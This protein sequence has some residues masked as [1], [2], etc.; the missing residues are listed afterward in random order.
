MSRAEVLQLVAA[1]L[2]AFATLVSAAEQRLVKRLRGAGADD[3]ERAIQLA[4]LS[5]LPRWRLSRLLG[6]GAVGRIEPG[7]YYLDEQAYGGYRRT[8]RVR[9]LTAVAI[10]LVVA[11]VLYLTR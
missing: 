11:G 2:G 3:P 5:P 8:R 1:L 4:D 6:A 9:A 7:I 10:G